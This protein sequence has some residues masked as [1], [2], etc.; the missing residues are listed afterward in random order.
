MKATWIAT[1]ALL[2]GSGLPAAG[3]DSELVWRDGKW[4]R[5]PAPAEGTPA[6]ELALIRRDVDAGD[7]DK[8]VK[9]AKAYL[10]RYPADAGREEVYC[11]AGE[12]ELRR[13]KH[14]PAHVWYKKLLDEFPN[15]K[16]LER[17]LEREM[18]IAKAF[19]AGKKRRIGK[20]LV[21]SA[22]SD[23]IE[24]LEQIAQR[25][26]GTQQAQQAMLTV[27]DHYFAEEKWGDA[28]DGY[29]QFLKL[30]PKSSHA[31]RAEQQAAESFRR[32]YRGPLF[33][34]TPLIEA[35]QRYKAFARNHPAAAAE[36]DVS[37]LL[38]AIHAERARKQYEVGQF[39]VRTDEPEAATYY[40]E[41]VAKDFADTDWAGRARAA[42]AGLAGRGPR[43][44]AKD[45]ATDKEGK[46]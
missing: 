10:K 19:L 39:Y 1:V 4:V 18:E 24:I 45:A 6:G 36:A 23:G 9:H 2:A 11:L 33:D 37:G 16:R 34:E 32:A 3:Q 5:L 7:Y 29:D 30:F 26:P 31:P 14:W 13:G 22:K 8:A 44:P 15:G 25:V 46:S 17:A 27:A 41:L 40:F 42:L 35:E 28:A 21:I 43:Q 20:V 12:A 38:E